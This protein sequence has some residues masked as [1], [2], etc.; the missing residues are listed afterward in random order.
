[1]A[2]KEINDNVDYLYKLQKDETEHQNHRLMWTL[3]A[4]ALIF[5]ALCTLLPKEK[6][7]SDYNF[8][9]INLILVGILISISGIYSM[10]I[11]K[12]SIGVVYE[13]WNEYDASSRDEKK[14]QICH[15][16]SLAPS[17][18]LRSRLRW[19]MFYSFAPNVFCAA[20]LNIVLTH[21]LHNVAFI[22]HLKRSAFCTV[23][24]F[25]IVLLFLLIISHYVSK[26][27]L[28]HWGYDHYREKRENEN[29]N[30]SPKQGKQ[31]NE[32]N[33]NTNCSGIGHEENRVIL[34]SFNDHGCCNNGQCGLLDTMR[35][36]VSCINFAWSD[37][38]IYHVFIDRFNGGWT[39]APANKPD[40]I[41]GNIKGIMDKVDYIKSMGYN[42]IMLTPF[43][44]SNAY[45]GY[46]VI[47]YFTIDEHLGTWED[48]DKLITLL[49]EKG[50]KLICDYVPNHCH[51]K[52]PLFQDAQK[53][54]DS[55]YRSWFFFD[56]SK[57]GGFVSYQ[58][59]EDLPKFNLYNEATSD[60]L[61]SIAVMLAERRV[62]GLR[63]DHVIGV[64]F[65]FLKKLRCKVKE[66]NPNLFL[67]GEAWM[68][69]S[70]DYTQVEFVNAE[71][72]EKAYKKELSQDDIQ[73]NYVGYLDG[74]L[75]FSFRDLL[76]KEVESSKNQ[77]S[78]CR[79]LG[80]KSLEDK[81]NVHFDKYPNGF[82]LVLFL[83][84]HD[85]NRFLY[86]CDGDRNLLQEGL[87]LCKYSYNKPYTI[88]YGTE[89]FLKNETNIFNEEENMDMHVREP[90]SW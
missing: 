22:Y 74:V 25:I 54:T 51:I 87:I 35:K 52:H 30:D 11:S 70:L 39:T 38:K 55:P 15:R 78:N 84:N 10:L 5:A 80:N 40:F 8:V 26:Y 89:R 60:Y 56:N 88:Y 76:V 53:N 37:F 16:V 18:F 48:F 90:M 9:I 79:L 58:N 4:Q 68:G 72:K 45:H 47:D 73:L 71:Q 57:K 28:Y 20:W 7:G 63:I 14:E 6:F 1:M 27:F 12:T 69:V 65:P 64:P 2:V 49:H 13:L 31:K 44:K 50:M 42:A 81:I 29:S 67:F 43:F 66:K 34:N 21:F 41:G 82:E 85:T 23:C 86:H 83:D 75:D 62:D 59:Y 46:H 61:I 33:R 32:L 19:L 77:K 17:H 24:T 36:N 3:T